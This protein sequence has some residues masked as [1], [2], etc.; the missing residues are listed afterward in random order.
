MICIAVVFSLDSF[1]SSCRNIRFV[2]LYLQF[3]LLI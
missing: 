1:K 2:V 3:C